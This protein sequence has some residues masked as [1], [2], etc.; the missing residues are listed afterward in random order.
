MI[1]KD[2]IWIDVTQIVGGKESKVELCDE[3]SDAIPVLDKLS[4]EAAGREIVIT[5]IFDGRHKIGSNHYKGTAI[6]LRISHYTRTQIIRLVSMV[7]KA[8]GPDFDVLLEV[9]HLHIEYDPK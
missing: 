6:D 4:Q 9:D 1:Y 5:A 3:L 7:Q 8:L 2:G